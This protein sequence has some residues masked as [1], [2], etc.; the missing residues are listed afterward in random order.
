LRQN[1]TMAGRRKLPKGEKLNMVA[2]Y[3]NDRQKKAINKAYG[4]TTEAIRKEILPKIM[5]GRK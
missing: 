1:I 3:L 2:V 5:E 4:N